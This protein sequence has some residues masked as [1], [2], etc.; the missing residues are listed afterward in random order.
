[1]LDAQ[2]RE[3]RLEACFLKL[4][5]IVSTE[6]AETAKMGDTPGAALAHLMSLVSLLAG[7]AVGTC[8]L[9]LAPGCEEQRAITIDGYTDQLNTIVTREAYAFCADNLAEAQQLAAAQRF[10]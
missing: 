8:A 2:V 3:D 4:K 6:L 10:H 7:H 5:E 1:M 9:S